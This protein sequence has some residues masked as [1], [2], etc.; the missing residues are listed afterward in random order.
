MTENEELYPIPPNWTVGNYRYKPL[1][2]EQDSNPLPHKIERYKLLAEYY[3]HLTTLSTGSIVLLAAFLTAFL[4][5]LPAQPEWKFFVALA[6]VSFIVSCISSSLFAHSLT[7][8]EFPGSRNETS[9]WIAASSG[10]SILLSWIS[11]LVGISA[12][13]AFALKNLW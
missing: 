4:K 7:V 2:W 12:L 1:F 11:L 3:K 5:Q 8:Y 10:L 6:L 9:T 13:L